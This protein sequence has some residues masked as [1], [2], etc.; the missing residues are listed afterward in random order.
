LAIAGFVGSLAASISQSVKA[1]IRDLAASSGMAQ[2]ARFSLVVECC[3]AS[4]STR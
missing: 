2:K 3:R 1:S 4:V